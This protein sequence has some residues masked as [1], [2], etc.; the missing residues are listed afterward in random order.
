MIVVTILP[1][2]GGLRLRQTRAAFFPEQPEARKGGQ[3]WALEMS[4]FA[5]VDGATDNDVREQK[6]DKRGD[7]DGWAGEQLK[8]TRRSHLRA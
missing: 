1:D 7:D 3:R 2:R 6:H 5:V 4:E 8:K